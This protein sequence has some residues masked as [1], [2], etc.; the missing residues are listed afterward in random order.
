MNTEKLSLE[1]AMKYPNAPINCDGEIL[2]IYQLINKFS[3]VIEAG[4]NPMNCKLQ[5]RSMDSMTDEEFIQ[6]K[7]LN[8]DAYDKIKQSDKLFFLEKE[9]IDWCRANNFDID[10]CVERGIAEYV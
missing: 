8:M 7:R 10:S 5:L 3:L 4:L 1:M 2:N 9:S 6:C